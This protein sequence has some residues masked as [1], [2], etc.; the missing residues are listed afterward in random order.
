MSRWLVRNGLKL[1]SFGERVWT[2]VI[3]AGIFALCG[4]A[5]LLE[6]IINSQF[7]G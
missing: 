7:G 3:G 2:A 4:T 1:T 5:F 6:A